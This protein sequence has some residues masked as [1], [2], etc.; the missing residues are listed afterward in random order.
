MGGPFG[1]NVF[2]VNILYFVL[3]L[4]SVEG[5]KSFVVLF[6]YYICEMNKETHLVHRPVSDCSQS[7][8]EFQRN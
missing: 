5:M 1:K 7:K 8:S 3:G 6:F 2:R 4:A